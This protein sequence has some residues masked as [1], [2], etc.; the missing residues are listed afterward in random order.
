MKFIQIGY[1]HPRNEEAFIRGCL[2]FNIEYQ[3]VNNE[4][5]ITGSPDLIWAVCAWI[6]PNQFPNSKILFGPQFFVFPSK[7][8][9][10]ATC[11]I[12]NIEKRCVYTSL[13]EWV[14]TIHNVFAPNPAIPYISLPFGVNTDVLKPNPSIQKK[15]Y[16][17]VYWKHRHTQDLQLVTDLLKNNNIDYKIIKYGSYDGNQYHNML[18]EVKLC[19]WVGGHESQGFAFQEALSIGV[20][21]L[22]YDV[23]TMKQEVNNNQFNY[24]NYS[25]PLTATTASYWDPMCGEKT[26]HP[27]EIDGLLKKMLGSLDSYRPREFIEREL[28]DKVCFKRLLDQFGI[29]H[30]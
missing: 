17:L 18:Q 19:I 25:I 20:P 8:G 13:S 9:P 10:L 15:E 6:D 1:S 24:L 14:V 5:Q 23:S 3:K 7:D 4:S 21:L 16:V 30:I 2:L 12:P 28:S 26:I 11:K 22:V 27:H 29:K